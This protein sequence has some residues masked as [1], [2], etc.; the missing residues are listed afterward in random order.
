MEDELS[1]SQQVMA[2]D[3]SGENVIM[4]KPA[5]MSTAKRF[6]PDSK[7][8]GLVHL[9]VEHTFNCPSDTSTHHDGTERMSYIR[10]ELPS[11]NDSDYDGQKGR[12]ITKA[13]LQ[14]YLTNH[15]QEYDIRLLQSEE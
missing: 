1:L 12:H 2:S 4:L 9:S 15:H 5:A 7:K 3:D 13:T 14:L 11:S 10:F 8:G 6:M